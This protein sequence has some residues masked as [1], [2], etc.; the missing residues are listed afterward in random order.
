MQGQSIVI[1]PAMASSCAATSGSHAIPPSLHVNL[2]N[3]H[4]GQQVLH[5]HQVWCPG[6]VRISWCLRMEVALLLPAISA[7]SRFVRMV[8]FTP[9]ADHTKGGAFHIQP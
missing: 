2:T 3:F 6:A 5:R 7:S 8:V 4:E 9:N 1:D